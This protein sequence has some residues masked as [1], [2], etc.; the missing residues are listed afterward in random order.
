[1]SNVFAD[2]FA[3]YDTGVTFPTTSDVYQNL[4]AGTYAQVP[5]SIV[6]GV[7]LL[8]WDPND[9]DLYFFNNNEVTPLRY[10]LA[11]GATDP[12]IVSLYYALDQL[13]SLNGQGY[14]VAFL[15]AS[16]VV[17]CKLICQSTGVLVLSD[18]NGT[19]L[20]STSGPVVVAENATH[21]EMK[22]TQQSG[23]FVLNASETQVMSASG[24]A[25]TGS[26]AT[27][28][29][30]FV[31]GSSSVLRTQYISNLIV[32]DTNNGVNDD[33]MG[34]RRVATLLVNV[35]D[36]A[37]Q[38]WT[39]QP[40]HRFGTG[41]LDNR[42]NTNSAVTAASSTSTDLGSGDFTIEAQVRFFAL[43][44]GGNKAVIF[45]K[46]D[47]TNNKRSYQLY[48]G[49]DT[50]ETGNVVFRISTDGTAGTLA[51]VID[52][53]WSPDTDTWYHVAIVRTS[54]ETL[55]FVDGIQQ[56]VQIADTNTYYAGTEPTALGGQ[57]EGTSTVVANTAFTGFFDEVRLTVGVARYTSNFTPPSAAFPRNVGGDP[58]FASVA[59]LS[60]F[61]SGVFDES[62]FARTLTAR[63]GSAALTPDDGAF[64]YQTLNKPAPFDDTFIEAALL[65]ATGILTQALQPTTTKTVTVGTKAT[66]TPAVYTWK[67][68][69][70][71]S[72]FEVLIGATLAASLANLVSAINATAGAGTTYGTG[73]TANID[74]S[75]VQLP[76]EQIE[77]IANTPGTVGNSIPCSTNDTNG[78]W[79]HTTLTG[80]ADIPSYSQF[81]F[82]RPPNHTTVIDSIT[83][84]QRTFKTD[85]GTCSVQASFVGSGGGVAAGSVYN[86]TTTPTVYRDTIE[87]DPDTME[88]LTP[89][90]IIS[91][92]IKLNRTA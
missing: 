24:L 88:A 34:D 18:K 82:A 38:G 89:S 13:P 3:L 43:P 39:G 22:F 8:P 79:A 27:A 67:T 41:I 78:S 76:L 55:F 14:I 6:A 23:A 56:G 40:R 20:A 45:G 7:G 48:K 62:S 46:W 51:E 26:G 91:G 4:L 65:P 63:N 64:N 86:I 11:A 71:G 69:L 17:I 77:V 2:G 15:D 90:T 58:S 83:L 21:L 25:I 12:I 73:T 85:S 35:D 84:T 9:T 53:P 47:E 5:S 60:G 30:G 36:P 92:K 29:L 68:A 33:L 66:S 57:A 61:D 72:A 81:G 87:V 10:V 28:Q 42:A 37:H 80:G 50:L 74:V 75:A 1:M 52:W 16:N 19:V 70:T 31:L 32:R 54:G 44:T 49:G 59:W